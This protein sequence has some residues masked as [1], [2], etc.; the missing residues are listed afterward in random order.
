MST[1]MDT[2]MGTPKA[3]EVKTYPLFCLL[4]IS[5]PLLPIGGFTQSFGLETYVQKGIVHDAGSA[6]KYLE[7]YL[8]NNF[9][10]NDLLAVKLAWEY[11]GDANL[12]G[13]GNLEDIISAAK[14]PRELRTASM[15]LGTR[16][17]IIVE[18][19]LKDHSFFISYLQRV[20][21]GQG[22][23]HY[24]VI[25]GLAT[26]LL[27]ID[28]TLAL[29]AVTYSAASQIVNNCA[30]LVP[31]SQKDGQ[32]ILFGAQAIFQQIIDK[33]ETLNESNLG[34]CFVGFDL[35]SMQHE[36]LYTRLY[37]S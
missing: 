19:V 5:D 34:I 1:H 9:L 2:Y 13:I 21:S 4:Q 11:T 6:K 16:F 32:K 15:K 33:V 22:A 24:S 8:L 25:Y 36:R 18:S 26:K 23:G 10:Y 14:A 20:K 7:S 12:D 28:K 37:I 35:R 30:K 31:I 27:N 17:S 29:S 3:A